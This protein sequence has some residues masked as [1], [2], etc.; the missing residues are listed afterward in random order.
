MLE[1]KVNE[2]K[3]E[4]EAAGG[5]VTILSELVSVVIYV[6]NSINDGAPEE[7]RDVIDA[8]DVFNEGL[9]YGRNDLEEKNNE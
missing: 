1:I 8:Y 9:K 2:Y 6:L 3:Q 7:L 4:I 5:A